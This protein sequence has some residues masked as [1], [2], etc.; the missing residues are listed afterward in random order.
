M[1]Y[2]T[3]GLAIGLAC[4]VAISIL[5]ALIVR[6]FRGPFYRLPTFAAEVIRAF[7]SAPRSVSWYNTARAILRGFDGATYAMSAVFFVFLGF[8]LNATRSGFARPLSMALVIAGLGC[9]GLVIFRIATIWNAL[10]NGD[11]SLVEVTEAT[12]RRA[13]IY[14]SPWGDLVTG[15][16]AVGKYRDVRTATTGTYYMQQRWAI[17]LKVG[18]RIWALRHRGHDA[19]YTPTSSF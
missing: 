18:A 7:P 16:A 8:A 19:L 3:S 2:V 6:T 15:A 5:V 12:V 4:A 9:T 10:R 13:R 1:D 14:G 17:Q 11:A